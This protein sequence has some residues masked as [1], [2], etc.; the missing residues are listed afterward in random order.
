MVLVAENAGL[1]TRNSFLTTL[2]SGPTNEPIQSWAFTV[3]CPTSDPTN[4]LFAVFPSISTNGILSFQP[5]TNSYGTNTVT[6][7][8]KDTGGTN[9][10]GV[11]S[12]TNS[13]TLAANFINQSPRMTGQGN[14]NI[15]ENVQTNTLT[16]NVTD[17]DSAGSNLS[18]TVSS[19]NTN[20]LNV[21][22]TATTTQGTTNASFVLG[23][24]PATNALGSCVVSLIA[25]DGQ[26]THTNNLTATITAVN[27]PPTFTL[28]TNTLSVAENAALTSFNSFLTALKSGPT[29]EPAQ[30]WAFTVTC[31][32]NDATNALFAVLPSITTNGILK[33][34]P[35][36][37][38]FGTNTV[39]V[40][41]K[42]T[43]GTTNGGVDSFT[44]MFTLAVNFINQAPR[45]S[46]QTN[47]SLFENAQTNTLTINVVD[48][49]SAGSNLSLTITSANTNLLNVGI[50][51]TNT[52][53]STNASFVVGFFP[54]TNALG[55]CVVSL[56]ASDGQATHT[57][58]LTATITAVNQPPT[59]T[60][61][62][63]TLFVGEDAALTTFNSF[64]TGLKSGPTNEPA[65]SWAFTVTCPTN[66]ATNALFA[67]L[68]ELKLR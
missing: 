37:N 28:S 10:G 33:L 27:Q 13:F 63:N 8:M 6:V 50:T 20:L 43:G 26:A 61:S 11:D 30:S 14:L 42:D 53:G 34:Q 62:T 5:A 1:T 18:L 58:N 17:V 67:V 4:L 38:S 56:I 22:L 21:A 52:P 65:Q 35:A 46:G 55:S 45:M 12:V 40:V 64:L 68:L 7:V 16:I 32:T 47:L 44:N 57:N 36:T 25:S 59:F 23:F 48:V 39:T 24:V 49:D 2:K 66:N 9:N 19:A 41:M 29:N 51:A 54:A 3:T 60:L 31:P 15:Y